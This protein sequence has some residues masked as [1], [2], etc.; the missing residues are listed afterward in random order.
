MDHQ[1]GTL[2][3]L[4]VDGAELTDASIQHIVRCQ[5]LQGLM[6]SFSDNLTDQSLRLLQVWCNLNLYAN[7]LMGVTVVEWGISWVI[8]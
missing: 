2:Q 4:E 6:V 7:G 1:E 5:R 3:W 8:E